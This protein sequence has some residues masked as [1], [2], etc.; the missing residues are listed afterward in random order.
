[1]LSVRSVV[2][3]GIADRGGHSLEIYRIIGYYCMSGDNEI[4]DDER[5]QYENQKIIDIAGTV[6]IDGAWTQKRENE[7]IYTGNVTTGNAVNDIEPLF[8]I[9]FIEYS[10]GQIEWTKSERCN[11]ASPKIYINLYHYAGVVKKYGLPDVFTGEA[12]LGKLFLL[13]RYGEQKNAIK[14]YELYV[15]EHCIKMGRNGVWHIRDTYIC[16]NNADCATF[17][18]KNATRQNRKNLSNNN[19][20][21]SSGICAPSA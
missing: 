17:I 18:Q 16:K 8:H 21:A 13:T 9:T 2:E 19:P 15:G 4:T 5:M 1:M 3:F 6:H 10:D 14:H 7:Y 12:E 11:A 20:A